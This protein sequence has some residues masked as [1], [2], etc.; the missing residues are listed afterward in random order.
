[1]LNFSNISVN[2]FGNLS[3]GGCDTINLAD[4]YGTPL[5]VMDE[6]AIRESSNFYKNA[7]EKCYNQ[8]GLVLYA[9]KAFCCVE[10]CKII[11]SVGL[12]LDVSSGGEL[13]TANM[14]K[15]PPK[16]I[17]FHGN[18]K[19]IQELSMAIEYGVGRIVVD[20]FEELENLNTLA[21]SFGKKIDVLLRIK[22][23]VEPNTHNFVKTG[24]IDSKFGFM[25]SFNEASRAVE[26]TLL[27]KN[28]TFKGLHF[29]VGSQI[30]DLKPFV[31]S[32]ITVINFIKYISDKFLITV[33]EL[34]LGGGF[35]VN[36]LPNEKTVDYGFYISK[37]SNI[38]KAKCAELGLAMPF[39]YIE[40]G[41]SIASKAGITLYKAGSIKRIPNVRTYVS[42][43]GGMFENPR[44]ALYGSKYFAINASRASEK[45]DLKVTLAGKCCESG[46]ILGT[47]FYIK[48]PQ[49]GDILAVTHTGAY[50]YSMA[51]NYNRN[52]KP[53]VVM[54]N[55]GEHRVIVKRQT[56]DDLISNDV[57]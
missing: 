55:N 21:K 6:N 38:I 7:I 29:H 45:P 44:Y 19:T 3:I 25:I 42:V 18:N 5:Y 4:C 8:N 9:C 57:I 14:A 17:H 10:I 28:V 23:E 46:D 35:G 36:Y 15:F 32:T 20:N 30:S 40:P 24:Q 37:I 48:S 12:G 56:Y 41:R 50:N 34:N 13:Y 22:P 49:I 33:E 11:N 27:L 26:K 16:K 1:M 51:S 2:S 53:A 47:D 39:V 52:P 54:V 31:D 43:D